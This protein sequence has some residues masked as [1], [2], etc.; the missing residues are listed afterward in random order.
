MRRNGVVKS[1]RCSHATRHLKLSLFMTAP[2]AGSIPASMVTRR[3]RSPCRRS[4]PSISSVAPN[5]PPT[6]LIIAFMISHHCANATS[7]S[8]GRWAAASSQ[9]RRI[10]CAS[11]YTSRRTQSW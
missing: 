9:R 6:R 1:S 2:T 10:N 7:N 5:C 11:G 4:S 3:L 8:I